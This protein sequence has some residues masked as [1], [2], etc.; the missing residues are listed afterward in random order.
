MVFFGGLNSA[1]SLVSDLG[2][3]F[4]SAVRRICEL[5]CICVIHSSFNSTALCDGV[6]ERNE[7]REK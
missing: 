3:A 4:H 7:W 5:S 6:S 1:I 2:R